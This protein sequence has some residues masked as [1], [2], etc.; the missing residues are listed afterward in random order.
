MDKVRL[1][2]S[3]LASFCALLPL[4]VWDNFQFLWSTYILVPLQKLDSIIFCQ[5][6][7][8]NMSLHLFKRAMNV[9]NK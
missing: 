8:L 6:R 3:P 5:N 1:P 7:W 4:P 2:H 9:K